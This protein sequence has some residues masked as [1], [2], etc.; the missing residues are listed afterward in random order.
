MRLG[1]GCVFT[2]KALAL[3]LP[4]H[5]GHREGAS[6]VLL[7]RAGGHAPFALRPPYLKKHGAQPQE[8]IVPLHVLFHH[9][10]RVHRPP[11]CK[12]TWPGC[13]LHLGTTRKPSSRAYPH[14]WHGS[15]GTPLLQIAW[16]PVRA[17][18]KG[19]ATST[20]LQPMRQAT[21]LSAMCVRGGG[22]GAVAG[23]VM[24]V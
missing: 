24:H 10:V 7:H 23:V 15:G 17:L 1:L 9:V 18:P 3:S 5:Q 20:F 21:S 22:K 11:P 6:A 2:A 4:K 19:S 12:A 8:L 14:C 16:S 13:A